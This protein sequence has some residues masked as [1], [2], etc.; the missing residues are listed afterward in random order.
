M[1]YLLGGSA[2]IR[3]TAYVFSPLKER[4][5][6]WQLGAKNEQLNSAWNASRT[7][8]VLKIIQLGS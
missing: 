8:I 7:I 2:H 6:K 1:L 3:D 5:E 4:G